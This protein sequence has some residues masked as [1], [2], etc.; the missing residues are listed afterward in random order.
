M[1]GV[2]LLSYT[3]FISRHSSGIWEVQDWAVAC[4]EGLVLLQ[5]MMESECIWVS[6]EDTRKLRKLNSITRH[7]G[8]K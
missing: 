1:T 3:L 7:P 2:E 8:R 5:V 4:R 6:V